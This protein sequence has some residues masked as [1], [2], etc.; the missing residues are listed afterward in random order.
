MS[1]TAYM[2][3]DL[4]N[5]YVV[6][7]DGAPEFKSQEWTELSGLRLGMH[8][9][10]DPS[11][12]DSPT[13]YWRSWALFWDDMTSQKDTEVRLLSAS[14]DALR[15][16]L[17][18]LRC[19][20]D[21]ALDFWTRN[22]EALRQQAR[23]LQYCL[24]QLRKISLPILSKDKASMEVSNDQLLGSGGTGDAKEQAAKEQ[25]NG[26]RKGKG[27]GRGERKSGHGVTAS[28]MH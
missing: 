3:E 17:H 1:T 25:A 7:T 6:P 11:W 20:L 12:A 22:N 28:N 9:G 4:V 21:N 8:L 27:R 24:Q 5:N 19:C 2:F 10:S 16:Q 15:K 14:N 26:A 23:D 13:K 18:D